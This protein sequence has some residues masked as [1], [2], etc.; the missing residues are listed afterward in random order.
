MEENSENGRRILLDY[1][2]GSIGGT[3]QGI[4]IEKTKI[5]AFF[6]AVILRGKRKN[7]ASCIQAVQERGLL[8]IPPYKVIQGCNFDYKISNIHDITTVDKQLNEVIFGCATQHTLGERLTLNTHKQYKDVPKGKWVVDVHGGGLLAP[9]P[10]YIQRTFQKDNGSTLP[11]LSKD[12]DLLLGERHVYW[13]NGRAI[14]KV[15]V[16]HFFTSFE[17]FDE[18]SRTQEFQTALRDMNV[19][20]V[21]LRKRET[22]INADRAYDDGKSTV[23]NKMFCSTTTL[24]ILMESQNLIMT[25]GG[26]ENAQKYIRGEGKKRSTEIHS[27]EFTIDSLAYDYDANCDESRGALCDCQNRGISYDSLFMYD[28]TL[29]AGVNPE[30][31]KTWRETWRKI[32]K[33]SD[34]INILGQD[35]P[36]TRDRII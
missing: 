33:S 17:E 24:G 6:T 18:C 21:V 2:E 3:L 7:V 22:A 30:Y 8:Q 19:I 26:R 35:S 32:E 36:Q 4:T 16:T 15:P 20:Y 27:F 29:A 34:L 28:T 13:W 11:I 23:S 12:I 14:E 5:N 25:A 1:A 31:L 9:R 10:D